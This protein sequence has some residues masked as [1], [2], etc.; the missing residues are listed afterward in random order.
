MPRANT[1]GFLLAPATK[2]QQRTS[3]DNKA[4]IKKVL[5]LVEHEETN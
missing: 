4:I 5:R 1:H 3:N 2:E